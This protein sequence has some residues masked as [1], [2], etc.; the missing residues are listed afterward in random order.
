[1]GIAFYLKEDGHDFLIKRW[2]NLCRLGREKAKWEE[3][4]KELAI[5]GALITVSRRL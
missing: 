1:M 2:I 4:L 3:K 5:T